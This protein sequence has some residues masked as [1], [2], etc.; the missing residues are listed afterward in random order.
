[1]K[2]MPIV[3]M[4]LVLLLVGCSQPAVS[5]KVPI[6]DS[7]N[8]VLDIP[9]EVILPADEVKDT[10]ETK[11]VAPVTV[12]S[13]G[14]ISAIPVTYDLSDKGAV[15]FEPG[16]YTIENLLPGREADLL[17][18]LHSDRNTPIV[19]N[20]SYRTPSYTKDGYVIAP[21]E[22]EGWLS[23]ATATPALE[24]CERK[25]FIATLSLPE[26]AVVPDEWEFWIAIK[27]AGQTSQVQTEGCLRVFVKS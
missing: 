24:A 15:G 26:D 27:E 22:A 4:L 11:E 10:P 12:V 20:L 6:L 14:A 9:D 7:D 18:T 13:S 21:S 3:V 17:I 2:R 19:F 16:K 5:G 1:M 25:G 8:V 23:F